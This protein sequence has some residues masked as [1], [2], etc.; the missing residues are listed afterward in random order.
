MKNFKQQL[1]KKGAVTIVEH[2]SKVVVAIKAHGG[3]LTLE[4][5]TADQLVEELVHM[6]R[7]WPDAPKRKPMGVSPSRF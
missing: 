1:A 3:V 2:G 7:N 4:G 5:S 6:T